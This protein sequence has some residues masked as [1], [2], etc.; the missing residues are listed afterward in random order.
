MIFFQVKRRYKYLRLKDFRVN[1]LTISIIFTTHVYA[2]N[3]QP[4]VSISHGV[5]TT[6]SVWK[7]QVVTELFNPARTFIISGNTIISAPLPS[8]G[9][10]AADTFT[11]DIFFHGGSLKVDSIGVL[12]LPVNEVGGNSAIRYHI[13][14]LI[15]ENNS[16]ITNTVYD[17]GNAYRVLYGNVVING[18]TSIN[19]DHHN[20]SN[21]WSN[22]LTFAGSNQYQSAY[23]IEELARVNEPLQTYHLTGTGHVTATMNLNGVD[24]KYLTYRK[25]IIVDSSDNFAFSGDWVINSTDIL[26]NKRQGALVAQGR[27]ALGTG[28][29]TLNSSYLVNKQNGLDSLKAVKVNDDS[30]VRID[31]DWNNKNATL[32]LQGRDSKLE[33]Y[34]RDNIE[35]RNTD[36]DRTKI[37][38]H[39]GNLNGQT[40]SK[41]IAKYDVNDQNTPQSIQQHLQ[42][43]ISQDSIFAGSISEEQPILNY[44]GATLAF[45]KSGQANFTLTGTNT[46]SGRTTI[47]EGKLLT[48][49]VN[50]LSE[51]SQINIHSGAT[52]HLLGHHQTIRGLIHHGVIDF[53]QKPNSKTVLTVNGDYTGA[54]LIKFNTE[55]YGDRSATDLLK[56]SGKASG[57][58]EIQISNLYGKGE[59]TQQGIRLIETGFSEENTFY[60]RNGHV[61]AGAYDYSLK[62]DNN[63]WYLRSQLHRQKQ[64]EKPIYTPDIGAYIANQTIINQL[65]TTRLEDR[66]TIEN[67]Q[68][69]QQRNGEIWVRSYG[70]KNNFQSGENQ[71]KTEGNTFV[72]QFGLGLATLGQYDQFNV[73][74][75]GGYGTYRG[76]T[77]SRFTNRQS[78]SRVQG[79]HVGIYGTWY[80]HPIEKRGAYID[81]WLLWNKFNQKIITADL[82]Q[83]QYDSSGITAAV[84]TGG[85]Y[86]IH[87]KKNLSWWAQPQMQ[88]IY[89]GV[90]ADQFKDIQGNV[91]QSGP[92]NVQTRLGV[93]SYLIVPTSLARKINYRPYIALNWLHN[94]ESNSVLI[95]HVNYIAQGSK[96]LSELKLGVEGNITQNSQ[97]WVNMSYVRGGHQYQ[98]YQGNI[99]WQYHF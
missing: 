49:A 89:Q 73:G 69:L 51:Q 86:L 84:E 38:V 28:M 7:P 35:K 66:S 67:S 61:S 64:N 79:H 92:H 18:N 23:D 4:I 46:Y 71:L 24:D 25:S 80:S 95:N 57:N 9:T 74:V 81:S 54:G 68:N 50:T 58:T 30:T 56:I 72:T 13:P 14:Q 22:N 75:L 2:T 97:V 90:K 55:L 91:I 48:G 94:T 3:N 60:L 53:G 12:A 47:A 62:L 87:Q 93:K 27:N 43:N 33:I 17:R 20:V 77:R 99:G 1:I 85:N 6:P 96:N 29:V 19:F 76:D 42:V 31:G 32:D 8:I 83:Y 34:Y 36:L 52:L 82:H 5:W 63:N 15:L 44:E 40:D 37:E 16:T 39:I 10:T 65:F 70:A 78:S 41:I 11:R 59:Q 98:A 88:V 26:R 45:T 21:T